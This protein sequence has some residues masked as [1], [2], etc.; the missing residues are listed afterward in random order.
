M[1]RRRS[2]Q[3]HSL[4]ARERG[5]GRAIST[6]FLEG[7]GGRRRG[8]KKGAENLLHKSQFT[9]VFF[10]SEREESEKGHP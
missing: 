7:E 2:G 5:R 4:W 3:W 6:L 8:Q 1:R 9:G 10:V